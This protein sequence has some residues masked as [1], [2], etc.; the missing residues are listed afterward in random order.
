M[1]AMVK[2]VIASDTDPY[3][4]IGSLLE[5]IDTTLTERIPAEKRGEV[6]VMV[7]RLLRDLLKANGTI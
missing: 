1:I 4:L 5:A 7:L 3:L 6:A 2:L